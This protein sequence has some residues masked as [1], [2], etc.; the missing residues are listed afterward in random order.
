[1]NSRFGYTTENKRGL[2]AAV[3][4]NLFE[5]QFSRRIDARNTLKT[6]GYT[7]DNSATYYRLC[8]DGEPVAVFYPNRET[9]TLQDWKW[10]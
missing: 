7:I 10:I 5:K 6:S 9:Q 2:K 3:K 4:A 8:K 1:M